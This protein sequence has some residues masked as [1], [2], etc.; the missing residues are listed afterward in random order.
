MIYMDK[1]SSRKRMKREAR[2][3]MTTAEI[4]GARRT[5][6]VT[7]GNGFVGSLL[8][9]Q[10]LDRGYNVNATMRDPDEAKVSHL[11]NLPGSERLK[12]FRADLT[13]EGSF[14][15]PINDCDLVFHVATPRLFDS[16][17]PMSDMI[18]PAVEGTLNVLRSC[19]KTKTVKRVVLTSSTSAICRNPEI[20]EGRVVTEEN[21]SDT[22]FLL[23]EK[24]PNW[25]Y[26]VS[27]TLAEQEAWKFAKQN[28]IDLISV[29]PVLVTG[30]S[31]T[32]QPPPSAILA[33]SLFT[34]GKESG[35][36]T[37]QEVVGSVSLVH[38]VDV[39]RAH[40]FVAEKE[41][42]YG[43]YICSATSTTVP[44]LAM[45]LSNRY[46]QYKLPTDFGDFPSK[47]KYPVSSEK[48]IREGFT[49]K[50]GIEEMYDESVEYFKAKGLLPV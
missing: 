20:E 37:L 9:K 1:R 27:K 28:Q 46:P 4:R 34:A 16:E 50:F 32:P 30:P 48:L 22:E 18:E 3:R 6:C 8:V 24:P 49:F 21:W 19:A 45:F 7:G 33:L 39:C 38:V 25:G 2:Q 41:S 47:P 29:A 17:D 13:T 36:K 44:E 5:A 42:A 23:S 10:L 14:D 40:I 12:L 15:E 35:L 26:G 43:R 31:L 11:L